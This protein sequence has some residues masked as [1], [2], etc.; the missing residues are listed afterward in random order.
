MCGHRADLVDE[1]PAGHR[2]SLVARIQVAAAYLSDLPSAHMCTRLYLHSFH[3]VRLPW[4]SWPAPSQ[5]GRWGA[6]RTAS[7]SASAPP[8]RQARGGGVVQE[9]SLP[10]PGW[11]SNDQVCCRDGK[12][13]GPLELVSRRS[14]QLLSSLSYAGLGRQVSAAPGHH[15]RPGAQLAGGGGGGGVSISGSPAHTWMIQSVTK[16]RVG[17]AARGQPPVRLWHA[18][19]RAVVICPRFF[20]G[21]CC[22]GLQL[23]FSAHTCG[24]LA[25]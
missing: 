25:E 10:E 6:W 23:L 17:A 20:L 3:S 2:P 16:E 19:Q 24:S 13:A 8:G 22:T 7:T 5:L 15:Q 4:R 9:E 14:L 12:V 1:A 21:V 11:G 18:K